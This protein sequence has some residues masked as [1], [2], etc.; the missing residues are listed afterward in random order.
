MI[1]SFDISSGLHEFQEQLYEQMSYTLE[2]IYF[3]IEDN[4]TQIHK[5]YNILN[6]I[7]NTTIDNNSNNNTEVY[8][9]EVKHKE[10]SYTG[11]YYLDHYYNSKP[12][13]VNYE[14]DKPGSKFERCYIFEY[15]PE[16]WVIQPL[17]PSTEWLAN[18]YTYAEWPWEGS[19]DGDVKRINVIK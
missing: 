2:D 6:D 7:D 16:M 4:R 14:C 1:N 3:Q 11:T 18:A 5:L 12:V 9:L 13:W 15:K 10:T 17:A 19:W 8:M